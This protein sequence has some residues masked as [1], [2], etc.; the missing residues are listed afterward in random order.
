M[1]YRIN[2]T[3]KDKIK[4]IKKYTLAYKLKYQSEQNI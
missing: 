3:I 1:K 2:H 4:Y